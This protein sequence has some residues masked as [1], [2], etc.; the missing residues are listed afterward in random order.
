MGEF[1]AWAQNIQWI[2]SVS[3]NRTW[4]S[5]Y[6]VVSIYRSAHFLSDLPLFR[7]ILTDNFTFKCLDEILALLKV[8]K[9]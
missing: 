4:L 1:Y 2:N 6:L 5:F 3:S 8:F 7:K 9:F